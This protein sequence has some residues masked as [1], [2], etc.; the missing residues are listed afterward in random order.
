MYY[1]DRTSPGKKKKQKITNR[2][3]FGTNK[4]WLLSDGV[5][6]KGGLGVVNK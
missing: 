5:K 4:W 1:L 6:F 3:K 2:I